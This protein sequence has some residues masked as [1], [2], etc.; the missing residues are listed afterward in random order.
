MRQAAVLHS[1]LQITLTESGH[2]PCECAWRCKSNLWLTKF[3]LLYDMRCLH[4]SGLH[5]LQAGTGFTDVLC[6]S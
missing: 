5:V 4:I 1:Q 6:A 2:A 3:T